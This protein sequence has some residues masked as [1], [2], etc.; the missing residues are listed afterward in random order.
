EPLAP[1]V[2]LS[3]HPNA[4]HFREEK[5][6]LTAAR[7]R[8]IRESTGDVLVFV[9]DDNVLDAD[10]LEK[11]TWL[12]AAWPMVG[13]FSG[14]VRGK[15]EV[16]PPEWTKAYWNRLAI[17]EFEKDKWSNLA[18]LSDTTP[19]GAGLCVRRRVA[20]E[21]LSYHA[22]GKR[23]ILLDR[24][25][26][27]LVSAGD[28]DLAATACDMGLGNGLFASL[29]LNHLMPRERLEEKYLLSLLEAQAFSQVVLDSFRANGQAPMR[30][31]LKKVVAA[32]LRMLFMNRRQRR[33][34][35]AMRRGVNKG[36]EFLA[37]Q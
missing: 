3:W 31:G 7:L 2:D 23:K 33:F 25:G 32:Q 9:D 4:K 20:D 13:A 30:D 36:L 11:V 21:Y 17:R 8:G 29:A 28:I 14:Q 24:T 15:F 18:C 19:N 35:Q 16:P 6:G 34:F 10:Y 26:T 37:N 1:R 12:S 27:S 5:L 22:N